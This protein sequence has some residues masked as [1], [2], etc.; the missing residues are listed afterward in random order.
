M[1]DKG[2]TLIELMIVVA[3]VGVL[4]GLAIPRY[5]E[6][7]SR[8]YFSEA[9]NLL[10]G[11]RAGAQ[12]R[13]AR[14]LALDSNLIE[15]SQQIGL[16]IDGNHGTVTDTSGWSGSDDDFWL[17]YTFGAST[18]SGE[19]TTVNAPLLGKRVRYTF[20]I[21]GNG[22]AERGQWRCQTTA[23]AKVT[24]RCENNL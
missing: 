23:A 14:G 22:N 20:G 10:A 9:H 6:Y 15:L 21:T 7:V 3:I 17:E 4:A 2:F 1:E 19:D 16:T 13:I 24:I 12:T 18:S 5:Q 8:S 11:V